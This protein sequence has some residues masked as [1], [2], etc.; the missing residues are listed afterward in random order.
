MLKHSRT[1]FGGYFSLKTII[2]RLYLPNHKDT[3]GQCPWQPSSRCP[4]FNI[5][6]F[7]LGALHF[8]SIYL[9][10][11]FAQNLISHNKADQSEKMLYS[12]LS[13]H[14]KR[15]P[16]SGTRS[17]ALFKAALSV[18]DIHIFPSELRKFSLLIIWFCN[19]IINIPQQL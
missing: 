9:Y 1:P 10:L 3:Q 19:G 4:A 15:V 6:M 7:L 17:P 13:L 8:L 16:N 2:F 18:T 12:S 11:L 14:S 5:K